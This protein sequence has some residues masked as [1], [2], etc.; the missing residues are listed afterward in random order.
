MKSS[1]RSLRVL[2]VE[3]EPIAAMVML[4]TL[5]QLGY[6]PDMALSGSEALE[7]VQG[8]DYDLIIMDIGLPDMSGIALAHTIHHREPDQRQIPIVACTAY[9]D[10]N[11]EQECLRADAGIQEIIHK[12]ISAESLQALVLRYCDDPK[13]V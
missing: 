11:L 4:K 2:A 5:E 9:T 6:N 8:V 1:P 3:D 12:P 13:A 7:K 10:E